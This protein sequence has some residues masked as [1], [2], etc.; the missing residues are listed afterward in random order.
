MLS[1]S[2]DINF[3]ILTDILRNNCGL[4]DDTCRMLIVILVA[5]GE[6]IRYPDV[7]ALQGAPPPHPKR[8]MCSSSLHR[9]HVHKP[10]VLLGNPESRDF[11]PFL[12][13]TQRS[14]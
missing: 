10:E 7:W 6:P 4:Q 11:R 2:N 5:P 3:D 1:L 12:D 9:V 8:W 13:Q 14:N